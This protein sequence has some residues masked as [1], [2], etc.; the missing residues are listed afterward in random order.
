MKC[1]N[2]DA[3]TPFCPICGKKLRLQNPL[4]SLL[5]YLKLQVKSQK[6]LL[7]DMRSVGFPTSPDRH[8]R[9]IDARDKIVKKWEA[10]AEALEGIVNPPPAMS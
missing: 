6:K 3:S 4:D 5:Q 7:E 8:K 1:C 9:R 10:W 2:V